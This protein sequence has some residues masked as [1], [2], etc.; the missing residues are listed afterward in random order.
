MKRRIERRHLRRL[1]QE[2]PSGAN[3]LRRDP[4]VEG[5]ELGQ[6]LDPPEHPVIHP[7]G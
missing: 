5:G 6:R 2:P 1:R 4:I 3:P 7:Y